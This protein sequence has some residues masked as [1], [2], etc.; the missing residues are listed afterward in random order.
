[1]CYS[2]IVVDVGLDE[3]LEPYSFSDLL[4]CTLS[5]LIASEQYAMKYV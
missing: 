3:T 5:M 4:N 1:M 2:P